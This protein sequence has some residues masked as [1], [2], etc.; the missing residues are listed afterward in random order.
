MQIH[1]YQQDA[2]F[3]KFDNNFNVLV[4]FSIKLS[5][6]YEIFTFECLIRRDNALLIALCVKSFRVIKINYQ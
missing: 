2:F 1:L 6:T 4:L 5:E 3:S